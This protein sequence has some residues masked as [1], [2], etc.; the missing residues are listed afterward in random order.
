[1]TTLAIGKL[2]IGIVGCGWL[3]IRLAKHMHP[4]NTLYGTVRSKSSLEA[5]RNIPINL[6]I[7]DL[8]G[9]LQLPWAVADQLDVVIITIP[10]S[11]KKH[12]ESGLQ[13]DWLD[14]I[15]LF[16]RTFKKQI[17][18]TSSTGVYPAE[19]RTYTEADLSTEKTPAEHLLRKAFPHINI[20]RLGGLMG[21]DRQ[22]S[23]YN[24]TD[25]DVP[26]N[27]VHYTDVCRLV[28]MMIAHRASSCLY[29]VVAP[30]HPA[31]AVVIAEQKGSV[32]RDSIALSPARIISSEKVN[33]ALGFQYTYPDPRYFHLPPQKL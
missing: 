16:L 27:H 1:M 20:L 25:S 6:E 26:V 5:L 4:D 22:L 23:K 7:A 24:I 10:F 11:L 32:S 19:R 15:S 2:K 8:S 29:N 12:R 9:D 31:K 3:G 18:Y 33:T 28:E 30:M 17:F 21:D 14:N 13:I